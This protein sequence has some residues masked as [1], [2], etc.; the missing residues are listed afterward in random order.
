MNPLAGVAHVLERASRAHAPAAVVI[1]GPSGSGKSVFA[2]AVAE[3]WPEAQLVRLDAFYPGWSGLDAAS[4]AV[5][6][7]ILLPRSE[8][9][10]GG[11]RRW[12]WTAALPAE[13]HDLDAVRPLIVEGCGALS[14]AA[15]P[16][17]DVGVWVEAPDAVRKRR[18]LARDPG[19]FDEHWDMWDA[20]W[21]RFEA[22][23]N[24][25]AAAS[26]IVDGAQPPPVDA[27]RR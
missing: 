11:W 27:A 26:V 17:V 6:E 13:W 7:D 23:E 20:Q 18:A 4:A 12:D 15:R 16:F 9:R 19:A 3:H 5:V 21:R 25:R 22:R 1:D 24:P 2:G 8:G 14:R 10:P